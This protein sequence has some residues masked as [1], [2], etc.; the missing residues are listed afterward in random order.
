MKMKNYNSSGIALRFKSRFHTIT[1]SKNRI[2]FIPI[3]LFVSLCF[4]SCA[5][6][7]SFSTSSVVPAAEGSV[8]IKKDNNNN[9]KIELKLIRLA[10]AERLTPSKSKYVV[11]MVT[12]H[13][14]TKNIGQLKTS[15]GLFSKSLKSSL[16][17]VTPFEPTDFFITAED[18][19]DIQYPGTQIVLR[20]GS[21]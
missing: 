7:M 20:T 1:N 5:K 9:Y 2:L 8:K 13:D 19:A 18:D 21:F 4:S 17:T 12:E 15:S 16:H 11:W 10:K 14:G 3:I 6:K